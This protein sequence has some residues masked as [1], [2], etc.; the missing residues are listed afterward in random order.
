MNPF[1][2]SS[3]GILIEPI[4]VQTAVSRIEKLKR[5]TEGLPVAEA[6]GGWQGPGSA[7]MDELISRTESLRTAL[8]AMLENAQKS[9]QEASARFEETDSKQAAS[10]VY[11]Q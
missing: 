8:V 4:A 11:E 5:Y 10:Y 7:A 6:G 9:L 3:S 2:Y 1:N